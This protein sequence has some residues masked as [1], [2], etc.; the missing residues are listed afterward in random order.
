MTADHHAGGPVRSPAPPMSPAI[1]TIYTTPPARASHTPVAPP[2]EAPAP[3]TITIDGV[4]VSVP[5]GVTID[6]KS[7]V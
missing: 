6:R 2:V 5:S 3:V 1:E 7:V 4:E